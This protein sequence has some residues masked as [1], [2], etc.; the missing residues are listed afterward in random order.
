[1]LKAGQSFSYLSAF[2]FAYGKGEV[3]GQ[4]NFNFK[5]MLESAKS[6]F[7]FEFKIPKIIGAKCTVKFKVISCLEV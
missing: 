5:F 1:M 7:K 2:L 4:F 3:S 6:K